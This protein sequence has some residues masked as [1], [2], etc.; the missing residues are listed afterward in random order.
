MEPV[1]SSLRL[2]SSCL[3]TICSALFAQNA[4]NFPA[5]LSISVPLSSEGIRKLAERVFRVFEQYR[6]AGPSAISRPDISHPHARR[7]RGAMGIGQ[8][9]CPIPKPHLLESE[10]KPEAY[11]AFIVNATD[12]AN[13]SY[14]AK[15]TG[16]NVG[17]R[18][19]KVRSVCHIHR[20]DSSFRLQPFK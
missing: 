6:M 2:E 12:R 1:S 9:D 17:V 18:V 8:Y 13:T 5:I 20:F 10:F 19:G 4:S 3:I 15:S 11:V 16:G 7:K 14:G